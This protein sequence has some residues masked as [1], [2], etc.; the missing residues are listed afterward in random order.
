MCI[1]YFLLENPGYLLASMVA[2]C[3]LLTVILA[4]FSMNKKLP[5]PST[6]SSKELQQFIAKSKS[7]KRDNTSMSDEP[8]LGFLQNATDSVASEV[9]D[10]VNTGKLDEDIGISCDGAK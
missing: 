3:I 2:L 10:G 6:W 4:K 5:M 9:F 7:A 8:F 1:I